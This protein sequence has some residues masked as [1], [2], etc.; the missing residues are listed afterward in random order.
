MDHALLIKHTDGKVTLL[1]IYADDMVV[2]DNNIYKILKLQNY[3]ASYIV[4]KDLGALKYFLNIFWKLNW[5][6]YYWYL[7]FQTKYIQYL[8]L[9]T[10]VL[11]RLS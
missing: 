6:I 1:I 10:I 7:S 9:E 2:T 3:L 4:R 11:R 5:F 8:L